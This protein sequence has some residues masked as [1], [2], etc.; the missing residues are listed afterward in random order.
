MAPYTFIRT[1]NDL[2][3]HQV[4]QFWDFFVSI[5]I[6]LANEH[7]KDLQIQSTWP[8]SC[9]DRMRPEHRGS[10]SPTHA[11]AGSGGNLWKAI[12]L[13]IPL[14][15]KKQMLVVFHLRE[16]LKGKY[17]PQTMIRK[18]HKNQNHTALLQSLLK[19]LDTFLSLFLVSLAESPLCAVFLIN[20]FIFLTPFSS[21]QSKRKSNKHVYC[22]VKSYFQKA[23][24]FAQLCGGLEIKLEARFVSSSLEPYT[25]LLP[26]L[27][28]SIQSSY[29]DIQTLKTML[30]TLGQ[31]NMCLE[32]FPIRGERWCLL[33]GSSG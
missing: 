23:T 2:R 31:K 22:W 9:G 24:S 28:L 10:P 11:H 18:S 3:Y 25:C 13:E 33:T 30:L 14:Y 7:T 21:V 20:S 26:P 27:S 19:R 8:Q 6:F 5:K 15:V 32:P 1:R 17:T 12:S 16:L 4:Q 29:M